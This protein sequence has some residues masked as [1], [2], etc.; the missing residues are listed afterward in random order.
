VYEGIVMP[1]FLYGSEVW[2]TSA[3]DIR[4]IS[5]MEIECMRAMCEVSILDGVR[6]KKV[7]RRCSSELSIVERLD[8]NVL[9]WN[10]HVER[11]V[12]ESG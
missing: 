5:V 7:R 6:N 11:M 3:E 9:R 1:T 2:A 4:R 12:E 8:G 10:G